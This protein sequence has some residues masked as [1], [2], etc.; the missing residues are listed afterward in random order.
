MIPASV[1]S[2]IGWGKRRGCS[3]HR[4]RRAHPATQYLRNNGFRGKT[5]VMPGRL[6]FGSSRE[7]VWQLN[8]DSAVLAE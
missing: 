7:L 8:T 5:A 4:R 2:S 3:S 1:A 6:I